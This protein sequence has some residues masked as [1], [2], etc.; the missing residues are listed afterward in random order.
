MKGSTGPSTDL[1]TLVTSNR[2]QGNFMKLNEGRFKLDIRK[3]FFT[4]WVVGHFNNLPREVVTT[5]AE[6]KK[7]LDN[8]LRHMVSFLRCSTEAKELDLMILMG[9]FQMSMFYDFMIKRVLELKM[10]YDFVIE[11]SEDVVRIYVVLARPLKGK[12]EVDQIE[13]F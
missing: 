13:Q 11:V 6:H 7:C 3:R 8:A 9:P 2:T 4:R 12:F 1:F 10:G 5:L